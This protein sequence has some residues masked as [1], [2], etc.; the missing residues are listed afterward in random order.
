MNSNKIVSLFLVVLFTSA[1][2][3]ASEKPCPKDKDK[4][5]PEHQ[6]GWIGGEYKLARRQG[7]LFMSDE[8]VVEAFLDILMKGLK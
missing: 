3:F 8:T 6:R 7:N 5:P 4:K 2:S 1:T